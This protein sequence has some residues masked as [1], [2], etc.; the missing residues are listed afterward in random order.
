VPGV[1]AT[2]GAFDWLHLNAAT[3]VGPN[4]WYDEGDKRFAPNNVIVSSRQA[5]FLA[6]I[7]RD[8]SIVWQL[9]PDFSVS[10][11]LRAIRQIIGQHHAHFIPKGW[12]GAGN[13]LVF[14]NG[15]PSGYGTP[16]PIALDGQNIYARPTS[17]VLE[18]DPV[19]LKLVWSYTSPTFFATNISGRKGCRTGTRYHGRPRWRLARGDHDGRI[20]GIYLP[21]S[22]GRD[23][24]LGLS[25]HCLL[26]DTPLSVH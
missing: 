6:V 24:H 16:S 8:G 18:I 25:P 20:V 4:H 5:S 17:R 3:Y 22:Q 7:A 14:D 19:A 21:P 15:G 13:V 2:R 26:M 11:E 12:P 10:P 1:N 9:G 23:H